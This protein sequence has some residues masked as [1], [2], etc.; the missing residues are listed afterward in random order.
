M[1]IIVCIKQVP[2]SNKVKTDPNTGVLIRESIDTTLNNYDSYALEAALK[3]KDKNNCDV[4]AL[5]MGPPQSSSVLN[6]AVWMGCNKG[7]LLTDRAFGGADV[8][9]TAY[10]LT[11]GISLINNFD[12]IICGKQTTDGDTGQVGPEI[13]E[14]LNIPHICYVVDIIEVKEKSVVVKINMDH[15]YET[16]EVGLPCLLTIEENNNIP[17]LP[18]YR[19]MISENNNIIT[20]S[21]NDVYDK[22]LYHYGLK[23]SATQVEKIYVPNIVKNKTIFEGTLDE[24]VSSLNKILKKDGLV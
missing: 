7:V 15:T 2:S 8:L 24:K 5:T 3:I 22:D 9:A 6:E 13:A 16:W 4:Y 1:K 14:M 11:Q 20:Y 21:F 17:R 10:A 18:S 23:G 19:R 12:L